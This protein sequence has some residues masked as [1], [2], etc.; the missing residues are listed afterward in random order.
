VYHL[1]LDCG[2]DNMRV[3]KDGVAGLGRIEPQ[4][5]AYESYD[6]GDPLPPILPSLAPIIYI[7]SADCSCNNTNSR[8]LSPN[9]NTSDSR[10]S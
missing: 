2:V 8:V 3:F 6:V 4:V 1:G 9:F 5:K 10:N 7:Y